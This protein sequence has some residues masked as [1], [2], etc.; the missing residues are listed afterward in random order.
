MEISTQALVAELRRAGLPFARVNT[1]DPHDELSNRGRWTAHN[2]W[3]ALRHIRQALREAFRRDV[4]AVY[5]PISQERPAFYRDALLILIARVARKPV[6]VHLHG[7]AFADFFAR[8]NRPMKALIRATVGRAALGIVLSERLRPALECVLPRE[9]VTPVLI[10]VDIPAS[11]GSPPA[12][13]GHLRA[14]FF[15]TLLPEKGLFVFI[16]ALAIARRQVP[17]LHGEIAGNWT[18]NVRVEAER[19][20]RELGLADAVAFTGTVSGDDKVRM[21]ER[22]TLLCLPTF[23]QLEGT[24]SVVVEAMAAGVPVVATAWRGIPDLVGEAGVLVPEPSPELF[25]HELV[26]LARDRE[27]RARLARAGRDRYREHFTQQAF[28]RRIV[29]ALAPF[30]GHPSRGTD[31]SSHREQV[32]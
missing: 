16:K 22:A 10:G 19:R 18:G 20:V 8:E 14:L 2:V 3:L 12:P 7:G 28:G 27:L 17:E 9:R 23:F 15:S 31:S 30:V 24:P 1:N 11:D 4:C 13:D 26:R 5:V 6:V 32:E 21:F 29:Q 25:A